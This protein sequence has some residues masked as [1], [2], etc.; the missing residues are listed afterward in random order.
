MRLIFET[1]SQA[2]EYA[3]Y[4]SY[5]LL[6]L[7][8]SAYAILQ[9]RRAIF[10]S[11]LAEDPT[12]RTIS[13]SLIWGGLPISVTYFEASEGLNENG[14]DLSDEEAKKYT[15]NLGGDGFPKIPDHQIW[16]A[17]DTF[18]IP[19]TYKSGYENI[20]GE[21]YCDLSCLHVYEDRFMFEG[22][23]KHS[24]FSFETHSLYYSAF[25]NL[26]V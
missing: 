7:D 26:T 10:T 11:L 5:A 25:D 18:T 17:P 21:V 13:Y 14:E 19:P 12:L 22:S 1:T 8:K 3:S 9:K 6:E 20:Q 15:M 24:D 16:I 2:D 4:P 23:E